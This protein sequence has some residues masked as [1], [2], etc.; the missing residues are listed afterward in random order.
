M[1]VKNKFENVLNLSI[2]SINI[3]AF[4][5]KAEYWTAIPALIIAGRELAAIDRPSRLYNLVLNVWLSYWS[6]ASKG[7]RSSLDF[8][9]SLEIWS[10][11]SKNFRSSLERCST[12]PAPKESPRT[13]TAVRN[14]PLE[15][16]KIARTS[17]SWLNEPR[18]EKTCICTM[19]TTKVQISLRIRAVWSAPLLF[20]P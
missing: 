10:T 14:R 11:A 17:V 9:S 18:N 20:A 3:R 8:R 2:L 6:T 19:R 16:Q 5:D 13:L 4:Y 12:M 1:F 7:I 15:D